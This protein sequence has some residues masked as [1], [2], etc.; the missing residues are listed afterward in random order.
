MEHFLKVSNFGVIGDDVYK[1]M[2]DSH[3]MANVTEAKIERDTIYVKTKYDRRAFLVKLIRQVGK[4]LQLEKID[5]AAYNA[6]EGEGIL[7]RV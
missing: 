7:F 5:E 4:G 2:V 3:L 6:S 1:R